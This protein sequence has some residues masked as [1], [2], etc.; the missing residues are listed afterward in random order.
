MGNCF[1]MGQGYVYFIVLSPSGFQVSV[2]PYDAVYVS[3]SLLPA[4]VDFWHNQVVPAFEER[5]RMGRDR[6][7]V[8][9]IPSAV[10]K[11]A[12]VAV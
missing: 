5:D 3:Q 8:G 1:L 9:W 4:L 11:R 10:R 7:P 6:A 2:E 12:A